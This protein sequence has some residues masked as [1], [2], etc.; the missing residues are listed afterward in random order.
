MN[1][2]FLVAGQSL[3][4][5]HGEDIY[6]ELYL[7]KIRMKSTL[8]M[9]IGLYLPRNHQEIESTRI[10]DREILHN[11]FSRKVFSNPFELKVKRLGEGGTQT[12]DMFILP[13]ILC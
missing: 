13:E 5:Y 9:K 8:E 7:A 6:R 10:I 12:F 2:E 3:D 1:Q 11:K 4:K